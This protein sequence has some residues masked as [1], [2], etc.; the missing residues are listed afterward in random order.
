M[1]ADSAGVLSCVGPLE[2]A[3]KGRH[4]LKIGFVTIDQNTYV[5]DILLP[6]KDSFGLVHWV[7]E[8]VS[9]ALLGAYMDW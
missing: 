5:A 3:R 2:H 4:V 9:A 8:R 1:T 7:F 6:R